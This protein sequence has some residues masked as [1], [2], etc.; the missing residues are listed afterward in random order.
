MGTGQDF[1]DTVF[2]GICFERWTGEA[3]HGLA[4]FLFMA[5][6]QGAGMTETFVKVRA[7]RWTAS[8]EIG[9][10]SCRERV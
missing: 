1:L 10:A 9:R 7:T 3:L 8:A 2:A 5:L 6:R 4:G